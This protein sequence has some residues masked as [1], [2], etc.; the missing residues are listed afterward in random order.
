MLANLLSRLMFVGFALLLSTASHA[1]PRIAQRFDS[2]LEKQ[3]D[4]I[5]LP[6]IEKQQAVGYA[7]GLVQEGRVVFAK[8]YGLAD[9]EASIPVDRKTMFRWASVSKPVTAIAALQLVEK[10]KLDLDRDIRDS[11]PEFDK[12]V[13]ITMRQILCHQSGIRHYANGKIIPNLRQY[14]GEHPF[15]S[16]ILALDEFRDSPLLFSPGEQFSYSTH[17]YILASAVVER[18]GKEAFW[19]Q[20]RKRIARPAGMTTFQPDYQWIEIPFRAVGYRKTGDRIA[21]SGNSDVSWKLGGGGF[22][23]NIDDFALFASAIV[24][25][26]FL[27]PGTWNEAWTPQEDN[28]GK[29]HEY[30]LGFRVTGL[31]EDLRVEHSGAQQKTRTHLVTLPNLGVAVVAMSNSEFAN[32]KPICEAL[33]DV[34]VPGASTR[35][36][37]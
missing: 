11:V 16:V 37:S 20:V 14:K 17:A 35:T 1:A 33:L 34:V 32:P 8:G 29:P 21:R 5:V 3:V 36:G 7:V 28:E 12:G 9:R 27:K 31:G 10:G 6:L 19:R 4:E 18:A 2:H 23:S 25:R 30:G 24:R 13:P 22:V 15:E 26:D